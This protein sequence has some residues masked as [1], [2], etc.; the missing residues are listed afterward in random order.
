MSLTMNRCEIVTI[1]DDDDEEINGSS[2]NVS[3]E[4]RIGATVAITKETPINIQSLLGTS[5]PPSFGNRNNSHIIQVL[6][7]GGRL[8]L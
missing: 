2:K 7:W 3:A 8:N 1:S 4:N 5:T 6:S